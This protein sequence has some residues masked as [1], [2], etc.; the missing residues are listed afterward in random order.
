MSCKTEKA[1][2]TLYLL[3]HF[4]NVQQGRVGI[5]GESRLSRDDTEDGPL[6]LISGGFPQI[7]QYHAFQPVHSPC[8]RHTK[9]SQTPLQR[10]GLN[11]LYRYFPVRSALTESGSLSWQLKLVFNLQAGTFLDG[12]VLLR[13]LSEA[14][15]LKRRLPFS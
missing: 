12:I 3:Q 1:R 7:L 4:S 15:S 11:T 2:S 5:A 9:H 10:V 8:L 13:S 14:C 6:A